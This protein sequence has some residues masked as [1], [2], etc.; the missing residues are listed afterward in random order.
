MCPCLS[1]LHQFRSSN[2]RAPGLP[3]E[4]PRFSKTHRNI[5]AILITDRRTLRAVAA[6]TF[7]NFEG[8]GRGSLSSEI[9]QACLRWAA[10]MPGRET[11]VHH[12]SKAWYWRRS[13]GRMSSGNFAVGFGTLSRR[14]ACGT[15][16]CVATNALVQAGSF[17]PVRGSCRCKKSSIRP[18]SPL[19]MRKSVELVLLRAR[20]GSI[21]SRYTI[22]RRRSR[23]PRLH[24][25][26]R[27]MV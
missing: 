23:S 26:Q 20:E 17:I 2:T 11:V 8:Q 1:D 14:V 21:V 13:E 16:V 3:N 24:V 27:A 4:I 10:Y 15:R 18:C 5:T 12:K 6:R 25:G 7:V 9:V 22:R 19:L